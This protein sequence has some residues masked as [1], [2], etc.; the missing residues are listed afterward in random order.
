MAGGLAG[1]DFQAQLE[2]LA[3]VGPVGDLSDGQ[4]LRRFLAAS[5]RD[6]RAIFAALVGR[7]GAMVMRVCRQVLGDPQD[8]QD[9][10]QATF[11]VFARKAGSVRNSE[12]VA[13]WLHGVAL[14][15]CARAKAD[16]ARRK[17]HERRAA[18]LIATETK[19]EAIPGESWPELHEEVARLPEKYRE[20]V[21]LCYLEGLSTEAAALRIGCPKGTVLSRLS[22]ARERLKARLARRGLE[23]LSALAF[24]GPTPEVA[25]TLPALVFDATARSTLGFVTGRMVGAALIPARIINLASGVLAAMTISKLKILA[26]SLLL[27]ACALGGAHV[28]ARQEPAERLPSSKSGGTRES[29]IPIAASRRR[30]EELAEARL[31]VAKRLHE[32]TR[33]AIAT[34]P[35]SA[36]SAAARALATVQV[37]RVGLWSRRWMEAERDLRPDPEGQVQ[38]IRDHIARLEDWIRLA[39]Q[40]AENTQAT[41]IDLHDVENLDFEILEARSLLLDVRP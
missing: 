27:G 4:L 11:L 28:L 36:S 38:A 7:H 32:S 14:R 2:I 13:S 22:R 5:D 9:A 34:P 25:A 12:S 3:R 21:V 20:A 26:F 23:P 40:Y 8:A 17:E 16:A 24:A 18:A 31:Q 39:G 19:P 1:T 6:S 33:K 35:T 37:E 41:G 15:V 10:F 29:Q 30:R